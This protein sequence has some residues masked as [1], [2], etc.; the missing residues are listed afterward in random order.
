[1][2]LQKLLFGEDWVCENCGYLIRVR[3]DT[4]PCPKCKLTYPGWARLS[5]GAV[6]PNCDTYNDG[7]KY[8]R[9]GC[10]KCG[11]RVS[12]TIELQNLWYRRG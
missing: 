8:L 1:M 10:E 2:G 12:S 9:S 6:C 11:Y 5:N 7:D 3:L 4:P